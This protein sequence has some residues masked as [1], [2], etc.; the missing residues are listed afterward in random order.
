MHLR[1]KN[2]V[3]AYKCVDKCYYKAFDTSIDV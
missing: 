3:C 2:V 1:Y